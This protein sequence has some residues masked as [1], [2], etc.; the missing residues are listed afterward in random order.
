[1]PQYEW[2][3]MPCKTFMDETTY[4]EYGSPR[5]ISNWINV[6]PTDFYK[7][8]FERKKPRTSAVEYMNARNK[9]PCF[10]INQD[11]DY[12]TDYVMSPPPLFCNSP[13]ENAKKALSENGNTITAGIAHEYIRNIKSSA[14]H[15]CWH[16]DKILCC[17]EG[18]TGLHIEKDL[19]S[20]A[21]SAAQDGLEVN[22]ILK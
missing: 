14:E 2:L 9:V 19:Y 16:M 20:S 3:G 22:V 6:D 13:I 21:L 11:S 8:I 5:I 17:I 1:M 18:M 4:K 10:N 7:A 12:Q 15:F